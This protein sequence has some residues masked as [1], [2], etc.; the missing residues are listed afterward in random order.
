MKRWWLILCCAW[1]A[2]A[3]LQAK[4]AQPLAA[5]PLAEKRLQAISSELRCLV[6]Q[7]QT[8]ADSDAAL[9]HDFR[10]EIRHMIQDG[11]SDGEIMDFMVA[12]YGDFVRYRPPLK[13]V[14]ILLW[15]GPALLLLI[16]LVSLVRYLRRR[17]ALLAAS[18]SP[19]STE[20]QQRAEALLQSP[21]PENR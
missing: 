10:R 3:P 4:E 2:H 8:I 20:E 11:R 1:L 5:D 18:A 9:A 21:P 14:T 13:G 19:L 7:N 6:C 16:G 12:R 17:N 15:L